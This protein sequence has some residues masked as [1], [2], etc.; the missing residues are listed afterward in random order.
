MLV[1]I[2]MVL[3]TA[4][5]TAQ[6]A[7]APAKP[8]VVL[9]LADDLGWADVGVYGNTYH[10]TPAIDRLAAQGMRF[11]DSYAAAPVC[12]PT[13]ASILTGKYPARLHLTDWIP[14]QEDLPGNRLKIPPWQRSLAL[15]EITIA[16]ALK[17]AGYATAS[18]GKWHL[19]GPDFLPPRQG[20]DVSVGGSQWGQPASYF[21][22]YEGPIR[23]VP[24]LRP[25]GRE[26]EYLTD[27]L[28]DEAVQFIE[29]NKAAPFFLYLS[30]YGVHSPLEA[31]SGVI[32]K[33]AAKPRDASRTNPT[34]AAM[35]ESVDDSVG[36]ILATLDTAGIADRTVVVFTSDNGAYTLDGR[37]SNAPLR[38]GKGLGYDGGIRTPLIVRWPGVTNPGS[39]CRVPVSS[40]DL[41]PTIVDIAGVPAPAGIDGQ[42]LVPLLRADAGSTPAQQP[43][44]ALYW[45]YPHYWH[46]R[47]SRPFGAVRAA[48]WKAIEFYEDMR[49][50]LYNLQDDPGET[51][52]LAGANPSKVEELRTLL[53]RWR[54]SVG[55]QMPAAS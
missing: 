54:E 23:T 1:P 35:L 45:H 55:A 24:G 29:Q 48:D 18:V 6:A 39:L 34:Y 9:I 16:E 2:G 42:S 27:R 43:A 12:S 20:F 33:Y 17:S 51:R 32:A 28:T 38:G 7:S 15:N 4:L 49:I 8:N 44:R 31:K 53:H 13:R 10:E 47:E 30:E 52:D 50:E 21:W 14:G 25:G 19:G 22:P 26:G 46:E 5:G 11:T 37:T 3:A 41:L 36:R 40:I